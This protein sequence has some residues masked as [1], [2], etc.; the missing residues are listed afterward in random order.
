MG[1]LGLFSK[2]EGQIRAEQAIRDAEDRL[3]DFHIDEATDLGF[4]AHRD[5]D[6]VKVIIAKQRLT[7]ET[8]KVESQRTRVLIVI[9]GLVLLAKGAI[10]PQALSQALHAIGL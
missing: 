6:R 10:D 5:V 7:H 4:H 2:S 8:V 9:F 1:A 3:I